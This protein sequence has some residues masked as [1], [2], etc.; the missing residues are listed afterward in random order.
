MSNLFKA[1]QGVENLPPDCWQSIFNRLDEGDL[2]AVSLACKGFLANANLV[3]E[4]LNVVHSKTAMLSQHLKRFTQLKKVDLSYFLGDLEEALCEVAKLKLLKK[5]YIRFGRSVSD[6]SLVALFVNCVFLQDV[7]IING[8]MTESGIGLLLRNRP[9]LEALS[10]GKIKHDSS[11][12]I[13]IANSIS[14]A[15][16]LTSLEF[17]NMNVSDNLLA[18]IAKA[19]LPLERFAIKECKNFTVN[20]LLLVLSNY[21]LTKLT[22]DHVKFRDEDIEQLFNGNLGNLTHIDIRFTLTNSTLL[23]LLLTK[24]PSLVEITIDSLFMNSD[25]QVNPGGQSTP[26]EIQN[27]HLLHWRISD[28][29]A[30]QLGIIFPNIKVLDLSS[31]LTLTSSAIEAIL[32]SC[33]FITELTL[34]GY[35]KTKIIEANSDLPS[36]NL[37][38]LGLSYSLI[39]EEGLDAIGTRCP[40]LV[41]LCLSDCRNV[42]TKGIKQLIQ[43]RKTLT[44]SSVGNCGQYA[45]QIKRCNEKRQ[46]RCQRHDRP[47][48]VSPDLTSMLKMHSIEP[49]P[50]FCGG[51]VPENAFNATTLEA[52]LDAGV[53]GLKSFMCPSGINDFHM[54]DIHHIKAGLSALAKYR[55]PLLVHSEIQDD[56]SN[57]QVYNGGDDPRSYSTYLKTRPPSWE[58]AAIRE[59]LTAT[60]GE[61]GWLGCK[62]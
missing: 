59:L 32:K 61:I 17:L 62:W 18:A 51:L 36:V 58:E 57:V 44:W 15:K 8:A 16:A 52:L 13:T 9:N 42:T 24:S 34:R 38:V 55:R 4:S 45:D 43:K 39:D 40:Q 46:N 10:I 29:S 30:Q 50:G 27:L 7:T 37:E 11:S 33:K 1:R 35:R 25:L 3:K 14:H 54:T 56:K 22:I 23:F 21:Y 6:G 12:T 19:K 31:C 48:E 26:L 2:G 49:L 60:N 5:I 47:Q 28:E 41:D 53:L 20:G